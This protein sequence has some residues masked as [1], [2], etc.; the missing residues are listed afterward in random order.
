MS[1]LVTGSTG[2]IG[3]QVLNQLQ[4]Q[5]VEVRALTRSAGKAQF[6]A[7]VTPVQGD[8][9]DVDSVRAAMKG[10]STAFILVPTGA[11]ELTQAMNAV[12]IARDEGVKGIV[13]LSVFRGDVYA[14]VP[15]FVSKEAVERMI[16]RCNVPATILRPSYF[17]QN[18]VRLK[19]AL[20]TGG[21]YAMPIGA[22]GISMVDTR[23]VGEAA[24]RE[25]LR[26]ER[27]R[28]V[29]PAK[30]VAMVGPDALTGEALAGLWSSVLDRQV[31]KGSEDLDALEQQLK[32]FS[33]SWLAYDLKLM[34]RAYQALGAAA[35]PEELA[36]TV[37]VLGREPRRYSAFA[38]ETARHWAV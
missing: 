11:D 36:Q 38:E 17:M 25:L 23:D 10:V 2:S 37:E 8:F 21:I 34:F 20:V 18:D 1:I 4:N 24:A 5:D 26:R 32:T 31:G 28:T 16:D 3:T 30:T 33:P 7:G 19:E 6:P 22:K 27:S 13:Y 29:L 35:S 14:D 15:H 9:G 12:N